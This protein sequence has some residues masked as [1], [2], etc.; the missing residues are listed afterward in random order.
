VVLAD[1]INAKRSKSM[2]VRFFCL[3][4]R[5]IKGQFSVQHLA[6]RWNIA[7]FCTKSLSEQK[8][9]QFN[10]FLVVNLDKPSLASTTVL[11]IMMTEGFC[12]YP[13]SWRVFRNSAVFCAF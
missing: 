9:E 1:T 5:I 4:N 12:G 8:F 7:D 13:S 6:G 10:R 3:R 11:S 2:D